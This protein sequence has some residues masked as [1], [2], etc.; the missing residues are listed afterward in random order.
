[1]AAIEKMT[2]LSPP[3][4]NVALDPDNENDKHV[5][6]CILYAMQERIYEVDRPFVIRSIARDIITICDVLL[7]DQGEEDKKNP[8]CGDSRDSA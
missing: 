4:L 2:F 8:D 5:I 6:E 3:V 7:Q 1:M